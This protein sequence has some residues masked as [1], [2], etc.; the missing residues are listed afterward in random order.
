MY[1]DQYSANAPTIQYDRINGVNDI[2]GTINTFDT[3]LNSY[4]LAIYA[5]K[6]LNSTEIANNTHNYMVN[7][8]VNQELWNK[9]FITNYAQNETYLNGGDN[10]SMVLQLQNQNPTLEFDVNISVALVSAMNPD[11]VMQILRQSLISLAMLGDPAGKDNV[12]I[13]LSLKVPTLAQGGLNCPG[14]LGP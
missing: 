9:I 10:L 2:Y 1:V 6:Q 11:W 5:V 12:T 4:V 8:T 7:E 13:P 14:R 3:D